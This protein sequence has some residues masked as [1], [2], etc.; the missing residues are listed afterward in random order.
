MSLNAVNRK[1]CVRCKTIESSCEECLVC[2]RFLFDAS[3]T[4]LALFQSVCCDILQC[5]MVTCNAQV[6]FG[7]SETFLILMRHCHSF[8]AL[9]GTTFEFTH[10][11]CPD[12]TANLPEQ[13]FILCLNKH[14]F[15]FF[16]FLSF[17]CIFICYKL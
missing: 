9:T 12:T 17:F 7:G 13:S 15:L 2:G 1:V 3:H 14:R 8:L 4:D 11:N 16:F 6:V 10:L 5:G